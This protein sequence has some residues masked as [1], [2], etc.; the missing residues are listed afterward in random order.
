[1]EIPRHWRLKL[2]RYRLIG[3][4][5]P[6]CQAKIFPRRGVCTDCGGETTINEHLSEKGQIYS[7]TVMHE[8]SA[9]TPTSQ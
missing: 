6:H 2:E 4:Q 1:M 5:C 9:V 7:F 8:A 3:R